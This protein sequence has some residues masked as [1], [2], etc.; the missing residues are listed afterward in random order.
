MV[1]EL[2]EDIEDTTWQ[3]IIEAINN[4]I[5]SKDW[6]HLEKISI[7]IESMLKRRLTYITGVKNMAEIH[8]IHSNDPDYEEE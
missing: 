8:R 2:E 7:K 6:K 1:T 5:I 3:N 4:N